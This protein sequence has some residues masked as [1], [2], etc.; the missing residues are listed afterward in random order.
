MPRPHHPLFGVSAVLFTLLSLLIA[1]RTDAYASPSHRV[2]L[3]PAFHHLTD[4][5]FPRARAFD[6]AF[7]DDDDAIA[8]DD[9]AQPSI[10]AIA[11]GVLLALASSDVIPPARPSASTSGHQR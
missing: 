2:M 9:D 11:P 8:D 1:N 7:D 10:S 6:A 3:R 5:Q 4:R